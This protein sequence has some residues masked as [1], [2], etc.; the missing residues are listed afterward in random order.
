MSVLDN[1][2]LGRATPGREQAAKASEI[3]RRLSL[4]VGANRCVEYYIG[5]AHV[6]TPAPW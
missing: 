4:G 1:P 5:R 3:F 2:F 6:W